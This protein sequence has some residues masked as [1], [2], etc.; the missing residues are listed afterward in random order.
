MK[1]IDPTKPYVRQFR[2]DVVDLKKDLKNILI[3]YIDGYGTKASILAKSDNGVK[4]LGEYIKVI[5]EI[6]LFLKNEI[7][8]AYQDPEST[9]SLK[10][11]DNLTYQIEYD[12][13]KNP[14]DKRNSDIT[15]KQM[16]YLSK[17]S[18]KIED[19]LKI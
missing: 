5:N 17:I 1:K 14:I 19:I 16:K 13:I 7:N 12:N 3:K 9:F 15:T 8:E 10:I 4:S 2:E 6:L 11:I 18:K